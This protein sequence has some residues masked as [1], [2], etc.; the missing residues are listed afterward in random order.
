MDKIRNVNI[1]L[2]DDHH[3]IL[4]GYKNVLSRLQHPGINL[5]IDISDNCDTAWSKIFENNYQIVFLDIN[6][7]VEENSK[8]LSGEDLGARIKR[9]FP[10]IK[11][12]ILTVLE[13]AFRLQNIL[14]SINPEGFLLKGETT[15]KEL[16]KCLEKVMDSPPYYGP[17][18]SKLLESES[19]HKPFI[20]ETDR[21]MLY[22]LSLGTKTKDLPKFVHLS[23]RAVEDRKKRLKEIF[24][25]KG[26][27]N[28]ALLE[29]ARESGYI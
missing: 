15:S 19:T 1:L 6:F 20:D 3:M 21:I 18:I 24:G 12:V 11:V 8:I 10:D 25:V 28:K 5:S 13:D 22:Q 27:G 29:K 16:I 23:L 26:E 17:K 14:S 9:D 4:E 7:P 2:V